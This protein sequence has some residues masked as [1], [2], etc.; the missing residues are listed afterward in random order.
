MHLAYLFSRYP[1]PS[2]TFCD[3]EMM[4]LEQ[5]G[6]K[7]TV[8][9]LNSPTTSFRH[10]RLQK[11]AAEQF[12]PLPSPVMDLPGTGAGWQD[13]Q[14]LA[15]EHDTAYGSS[16]KSAHRARNAW[17]L[18]GELRRRGIK[19][20]HVHFANR[21]THTALFLKKLGFTFSFTAHAQD[22]ML[23]LGSDALLAEMA[24]EA[25]FVIAV[26]DYS[27]ALLAEKC[28]AAEAAGKIHRVHNGLD[29]A[30]FTPSPLPARTGSGGA[31]EFRILSVGR[32]IEFK[33]FHHL[34]E[35]VSQ[36][37][38][39]GRTVRL[40]IVGEGPER[41]R[42]EAL[43]AEHGLSEVVH[44]RGLLS[45]ATIKNLLEQCHCFALACIVDGKGASDILP[46]VILEAMACGRPVVSTRLVGVPEMVLDGET[47]LLAEPGDAAG[48]A[49]CLEA[50]MQQQSLAQRLATAGRQHFLNHFTLKHSAA[51]L[52]EH[53][54]KTA[55][56]QPTATPATPAT[57]GILCLTAL[58]PEPG[59]HFLDPTAVSMLFA[60]SASKAQPPPPSTARFLPDA[61][62]LESCWR[63]QPTLAAR[64][65]ALYHECGNVPGETFFLHAR[66]AVW[67]A[68]QHPH[69]Q[70]RHVHAWRSGQILWA[71]LVHKLTGISASFACEENPALPLNTLHAILGDFSFGSISH[72]KLSEKWSQQ[73]PD[74]L[75]LKAPPKAGL[76]ARK[77][78]PVDPAPIWNKW[79]A[80][81]SA[82]SK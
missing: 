56:A 53:L 39:N 16:Y 34:I 73:F 25:E 75:Q 5:L 37:H 2:Q 69:W 76:F 77:T 52:A 11:L 71:W 54:A 61:L 38:T 28:P 35:S 20:V 65:E 30:E 43:I 7:I 45:Q 4:A 1:V 22:F 31:T 64:A 32:L 12:Y 60:Q 82:S 66:R 8:G 57:P 36:L 70:Y 48:F 29:P 9:A 15:A 81:L 79:F 72:D 40:D 80:N 24:R 33:G 58:H 46:T 41:P 17:W 19:H 67:T 49:Q 13:I 27:R 3:T 23:D 78:P 42:L 51:Q 21:A 44:L 47:G 74:A 62:V 18:S 63:G 26:S 50:L 10:E 55:A 68:A 6:W 59:Q 14:A